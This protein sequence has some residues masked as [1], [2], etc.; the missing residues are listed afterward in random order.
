MEFGDVKGMADAAARVLGDRALWER[1]SRAGYERGIEYSWDSCYQDFKKALL[2]E[3]K[4]K[5]T[6]WRC[7]WW[8]SWRGIYGLFAWGGVTLNSHKVAPPLS[9]VKELCEA[10]ALC[11]KIMFA[12]RISDQE[13]VYEIGRMGQPS[14]LY[15]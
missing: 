12:G 6:W 10:Y 7:A 2:G 11:G 4:R 9:K 14:F 13:L 15:S 1:L 5:V 3:E 8:A